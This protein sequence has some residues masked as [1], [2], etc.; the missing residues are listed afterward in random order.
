MTG[1]M[2]VEDLGFSQQPW[3]TNLQGVE[4]SIPSSSQ[5]PEF[6]QQ[7]DPMTTLDVN[8]GWF[9]PHNPY[10]ARSCPTSTIRSS[11]QTPTI[12][13]ERPED[14]SDQPLSTLVQSDL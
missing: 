10:A 5:I 4:K 14:Y 3:A 7:K 8:E 12:T 1:V 2:E 11:P 6:Y 13:H 9:T